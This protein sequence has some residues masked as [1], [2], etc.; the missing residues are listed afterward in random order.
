MTL[1]N[2][3][4][5]GE[6]GF[7]LDLGSACT[8]L[9][10]YLKCIEVKNLDLNWGKDLIKYNVWALKNQFFKFKNSYFGLKVQNFSKVSMK[11]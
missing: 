4:N 8:Q 1:A 6:N 2:H 7:K 11:W 9:C 5:E 10:K 3:E